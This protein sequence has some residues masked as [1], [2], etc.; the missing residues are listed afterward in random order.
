MQQNPKI[1]VRVKNIIEETSAVK[2]FTLEAI[3]SSPLPPFSG[4]SHITVFLPHSS[5][6]LERHYSLFNTTAERG[7]FEIAV[8]LSE[9]SAGGSRFMHENVK[10]GDV[11]SVS[12]PKNHF[13][14]SFQAKH[15]VFYAA[16]IGITPFLSMMA[17]LAEKRGSFELHYAAK[18]KEQCAFYDYLRKN[19]PNQCRF[20]FSREED[21]KR[22]SPTQLS[23]HRIGTHVYFCGPETMIDE[24]S[25]TAA[26]YGYPSFNVHFERFAP[27]PIKER[28][29][30]QVK[31]QRSG[32]QLEVP[33]D[34]SL[35]ETLHQNGVDIPYSCRAG[36]CGTCEVKV[37]E[38]EI[39][40]YDSFLTEEQQ[41][42]QQRMLSCVSRGKGRLV[43]DV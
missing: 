8:R 9:D 5:G 35:L 15:H 28:H 21:G 36:G 26:A 40:H 20:Y 10:K 22:L 42:S 3:D 34:T 13:Q 39:I 19:Y 41:R 30:F 43:L 27:P 32:G 7:L 18:T 11:L 23:D 2:R 29:P 1:E 14:L 25:K 24:F 31:L 4:G 38:G 6:T 16:G 12:W 17:E 37:E 33:A